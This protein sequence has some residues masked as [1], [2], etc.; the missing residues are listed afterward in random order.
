MAQRKDSALA[1]QFSS[2]ACWYW[3]RSFI[4]TCRTLCGHRTSS[5]CLS[6]GQEYSSRREGGGGRRESPNKDSWCRAG[7]L[8][9]DATTRGL[10]PYPFIHHFCQKWHPF[11]IPSLEL[12]QIVFNC[13]KYTF[14]KI[15]IKY[16][17][18]TIS[19][20]FHRHLKD[21]KWIS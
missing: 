1:E 3:E 14:L 6:K 17:T 11:H 13:C 4:E 16:K 21:I 20:L 19:R 2:Y 18:K 15:W 9:G 12:C 5:W 10:S 7:T 8:Y